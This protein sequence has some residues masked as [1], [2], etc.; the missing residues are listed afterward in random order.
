MAIQFMVMLEH[1]TYDGLLA[2][3]M[4]PRLISTTLN[5]QKNMTSAA[6]NVTRSQVFDFQIEAAEAAA[7]AILSSVV[8]VV[9]LLLIIII[10]LVVVVV[11][12]VVFDVVAADFMIRVYVYKYIQTWM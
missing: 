12:V 2:L 3:K 10:I 7:A 4:A 6:N 11:V 1:K 8:V 9:L 5:R